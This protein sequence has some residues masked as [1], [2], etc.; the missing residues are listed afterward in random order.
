M[1]KVSDFVRTAGVKIALW[2]LSSQEGFV[3]GIHL[4][5]WEIEES[6]V[7]VKL[8]AANKIYPDEFYKPLWRLTKDGAISVKSSYLNTSAQNQVE[9]CGRKFGKKKFLT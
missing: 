8:Q 5:D 1:A 6:V 2:R 9:F 7:P 3:C 4:N